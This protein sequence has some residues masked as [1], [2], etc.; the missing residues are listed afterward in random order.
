MQNGNRF[1]W[2]YL[3][4]MSLKKRTTDQAIYNWACNLPVDLMAAYD[5]LWENIKE[6]DEFDAAL[7]E[8]AIMWV[9]CSFRPL[10]TD[11]LRHAIRYVVQGSELV[12]NEEQ[13]Q[14]QILLLCQDLLTIDEERGVWMLPHASVAEYFEKRGRMKLW[15]CDVFASKICLGLLGDTLPNEDNHFERYAKQCWTGHVRRYDEWLGSREQEVEQETDPYLSAALKR[16]LGS[17]DKGSASFH[18][19][20]RGAFLID[21][22]IPL[23]IMCM[24]GFYYTLP[25][26]WT[27]PGKITAEAA[28]KERN[29]LDALSFTA[30]SGSVPI[31]RHLVKLI[32]AV[33]PKGDTYYTFALLKSIKENHLDMAK[34]L[35]VE[36][37]A[38]VNFAKRE[39]LDLGYACTAAQL[40]AM[41]NPKM[42]QW[43]MNK[44]LVDLE[45]END[46]GYERGNILIAAVSRGNIESVRTLLEAGA[47][48]DAVVQNGMYRSALMAAAATCERTYG[49]G[50]EIVQLLLDH[51]VDPKRPMRGGRWGSALGAAVTRE[52]TR[53]FQED[54]R[55]IQLL[56]LEAGAD[57]TALTDHGDFGSAL[58]AA[59]FCGH[60]EILKAMVERVGAER[61]V[62]AFRQSRHPNNRI[63]HSPQERISWLET[64]TYLTE[65]VGANREILYTIGFWDVEPEPYHIVEIDGRKAITSFVLRYQ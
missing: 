36:A 14:V 21:I 18:R 52:W 48:A 16:F 3:Q 51:G 46:S 5:Q 2:V 11:E 9:Q 12:L 53:E 30:D 45:R 55:K 29:S 31:C 6:H 56:L 61:A 25:D 63:F 39:L 38:D 42:L 57:P 32:E 4:V 34:F 8:R 15:E 62:E 50:A 44:G 47:N 23:S 28:L 13:T 27:Q 24:L 60:K 54:D 35:V 17:P 65:E 64:A 7:A 37:K 26:W 1:R 59:A 49:N 40:A 20:V 43:L 58:A 22:G 41:G 19:W 33:H 10:R